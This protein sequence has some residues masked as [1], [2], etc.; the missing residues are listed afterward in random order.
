MKQWEYKTMIG[1]PIEPALNKI[2]EEG[3]EM[4]GVVQLT[5][6]SVRLYFKREKLSEKMIASSNTERPTI[7]TITDEEADKKIKKMMSG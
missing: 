1:N 7:R 5:S 3:W 6:S 4:C 2:G